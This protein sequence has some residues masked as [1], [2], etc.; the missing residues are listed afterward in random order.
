LVDVGFGLAPQGKP[1]QGLGKGRVLEGRHG[2][3]TMGNDHSTVEVQ[4]R[5]VRTSKADMG[6]DSGGLKSSGAAEG[7]QRDQRWWRRRKEALK[8]P[9]QR[10][11]RVDATDEHGSSGIEARDPGGEREGGE[12]ARAD[13]VG[14]GERVMQ[15]RSLIRS[16]KRESVQRGEEILRD[17][18]LEADHE[19]A[20][21]TDDQGL[22]AQLCLPR[23]C[24]HLCS[25]LCPAHSAIKGNTIAFASILKARRRYNRELMAKARQLAVDESSA[26]DEQIQIPIAREETPHDVDVKEVPE[27]PLEKISRPEE[28][29]KEDAKGRQAPP[30]ARP[31]RREASLT[32]RALTRQRYPSRASTMPLSRVRGRRIVAVRKSRALFAILHFTKQPPCPSLQHKLLQP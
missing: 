8:T 30:R 27:R 23:C 21:D 6:R 13:C 3:A 12:N 17:L 4:K 22:P 32:R 1:G 25:D 20:K 18:N 10:E 29:D 19:S 11:E 7:M 5:M 26:L 2:A 28:E 14:R 16:G 15:A 24:Q 9:A 31:Q